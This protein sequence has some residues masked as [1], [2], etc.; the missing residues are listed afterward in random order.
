MVTLE[1]G[2][3]PLLVADRPDGV[4]G[5]VEL[6]PP[7]HN[8]IPGVVVFQENPVKKTRPEIMEDRRKLVE[9]AW[10]KGW[11]SQLT[12]KQRV[13]LLRFLTINNG[14]ILSL[15]KLRQRLTEGQGIIISYTALK[16]REQ[17]GFGRL[18]EIRSRDKMNLMV[19][20]RHL[21]EVKKMSI[22][23][24]EERLGMG[25]IA[26]NRIMQQAGI[27]SREKGHRPKS[28]TTDDPELLDL[29]YSHL[30][31][32][33]KQGST[34]KELGEKVGMTKKNVQNRIQDWNERQRRKVS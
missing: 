33:H 14:K 16:T 29:I 32:L 28:I 27:Q 3:K 4:N 30:Q 11:D 31:N 34:Y 19:E 5:G 15:R 21:Y 1:R 18:E 10:E 17:L 23:D 20:V 12:E 9:E 7:T 26:I 8:G 24:I 2:P 6:Q 25:Q 22:H 13:V